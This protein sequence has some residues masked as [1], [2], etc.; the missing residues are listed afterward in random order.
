MMVDYTVEYLLEWSARHD[1]IEGY[2][3]RP[4]GFVIQLN[5]ERHVLKRDQAR[6]FVEGLMLRPR[7]RPINWLRGGA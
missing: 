5:G 4:N 6:A 2:E 7:E 3:E 1:L